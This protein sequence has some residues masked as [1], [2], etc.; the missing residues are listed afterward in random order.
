MFELKYSSIFWDEMEVF[1]SFGASKG[2]RSNG[3]SEKFRS[4]YGKTAV[5][6]KRGAKKI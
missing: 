4:Q 6:R 3:G 2:M 5:E 1:G